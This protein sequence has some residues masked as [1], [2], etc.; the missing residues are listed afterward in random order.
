MNNRTVSGNLRRCREIRNILDTPASLFSFSL[1]EPNAPLCTESLARPLPTYFIRFSAIAPTALFR[2]SSTLTLLP[3]SLGSYFQQTSILRTSTTQERLY[4]EYYYFVFFVLFHSLKLYHHPSRDD[5]D[6][7][8]NMPPIKISFRPRSSRDG[9]DRFFFFLLLWLL[10][11]FFFLSFFASK[12]GPLFKRN[13]NPTVGR[14]FEYNIVV[15]NIFTFKY[16]AR[17]QI[18]R[19]KCF[20]FFFIFFNAKTISVGSYSFIAVSNYSTVWSTGA[21]I[22]IIIIVCSLGMK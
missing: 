3:P 10:L 1:D 2:N 20:F 12:N 4:T 17:K 21:H 11:F 22:N 16:C 9:R 19:R 14:E 6:E 8:F 18:S 15:R 13:K 5:H 7:G